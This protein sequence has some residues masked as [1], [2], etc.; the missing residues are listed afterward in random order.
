M[1]MTSAIRKGCHASRRCGAPREGLDVP[2]L[3]EA[4]KA[5]RILERLCVGLRIAEVEDGDTWVCRPH[6]PG[7]LD[8]ALRG[9]VVTAACRHGK[10]L[11]LETDGGH[12]LG[13]HLGMGGSI[14]SAPVAA[15]RGWD[16]IAIV[17][18]DE[19]RVALRD[20]RRLSRAHLG[21]G[22]DHLGPDALT[23]TPQAFRKRV[24]TGRAP[25][26]ARLLDQAVLA[27]VGN[28]LADEALFDALIEPR[29]PAGSLAVEELDQLRS[30]LRH[31]MREALKADGGSGRGRFA[32]ARRG[33]HCPRCG[34]ELERATVGGR[35][36]Y[37]CPDEQPAGAPR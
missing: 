2:E 13:L 29:R 17:F 18:E 20:K 28:L 6:Q 16:R 31:G 11:W 27:G 36:T 35:T 19:S 25:I 9:E 37:W 3:P 8:R 22:I 7:E 5:R 32:R 15:P 30:S 26:K 33:G 4:E 10:F 14:R 24:G 12:E 21:A 23:I 34:C 1:T